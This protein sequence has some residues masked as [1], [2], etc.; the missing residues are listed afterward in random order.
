[1]PSFKWFIALAVSPQLLNGASI[2]NH[3]QSG[4]KV[5]R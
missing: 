2:A 4:L 1:M 3:N 5:S